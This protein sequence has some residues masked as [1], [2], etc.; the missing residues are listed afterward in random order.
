MGSDEFLNTGITSSCPNF[1]YYLLKEIEKL[2]IQNT[3]PEQTPL[4][5]SLRD[6]K[7]KGFCFFISVI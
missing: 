3:V 6:S 1:D 5:I 2:Q 7:L 4:K